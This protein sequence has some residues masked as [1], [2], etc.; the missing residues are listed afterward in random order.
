MAKVDYIEL[1]SRVT[2][3]LPPLPIAE[4]PPPPSL[5]RLKV[6]LEQAN[7]MIVASAGVHQRREPPFEHNNDLSFRRI[8]QNVDPLTIRPSHPSPIRRPGLLDINVVFPYQRLGELAAEGFI[9]SPTAFHLSMQGAIKRLRELV[10]E[11]APR[12]VL[13]AQAA[14]ADAVFLVPL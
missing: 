4:L 6:P 8:V 13:D 9:G 3:P 12:M 1:I 5:A 7:V 14:G 2:A 11:T 10:T